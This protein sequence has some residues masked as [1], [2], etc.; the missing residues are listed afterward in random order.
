MS[1]SS[2]HSFHR[3]LRPLVAAGAFALACS[4]SVPALLPPPFDNAA[5]DQSAGQPILLLPT[6]IAVAP[7]GQLLVVSS[8]LDQTYDSGTLLSF[9][10][11]FI[12]AFFTGPADQV[13]RQ[14]VLP[15]TPD[16]WAAM[17]PAY[18]GPLALDLTGTTAWVGSRTTNR[19]T[20]V[21]LDTT[22]GQL[23][24]VTGGGQDCRKGT[25]DL[26]NAVNLD[27][28]VVALEGAYG[29]AA[30]LAS[31]AGE[32]RQHKVIFVAS[33]VPHI[34]EIISGVLQAFGRVAAVIAEDEVAD[35]AFPDA[36]L[37]HAGDVLYSVDISSPTLSSA[38][39]AGTVLFDKDRQ[40]IIL[41]G[42]YTR[43]TASSSGDP[44]TGKCSAVSGLNPIRFV[45]TGAG[46]G[47]QVRVFDLTSTV[48]G[49]ETTALVLGGE[50][51]QGVPQ[52]LYAVSRNPD[53][54]VEIAMPRF[55][56]QDPIVTR[57]VSLPVAPSNAIRLKR[58]AG[59]PGADL[60]AV[61]GSLN[62]TLSIY[63]AG[64]G[65]VVAQVNGLGDY[66]FQLT[67]LTDP[68]DRA[69]L[70]ATVFGSCSLAFVDVD[71]VQPWNARLRASIGK[72]RP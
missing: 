41:G 20:G 56:G 54:L 47:A 26:L 49:N 18:G 1:R 14:D 27:G 21:R 61:A 30:G 43:F 12:D 6:G 65:E 52:V 57:T 33:L 67:Q 22:T 23:S 9:S 51:A 50:D 69:R 32:T 45:E 11:A 38:I 70:V 29:V 42:C 3:A 13:V 64:A 16:V 19:A 25:V 63:D 2:R 62:G 46:S 17:V 59:H 53:V 31:R 58:P 15:R 7:T 68:G 39:G 55:P 36:Q 4:V 37:L 48:R 44:A 10:K 35:P 28:N 60:I 24:C 72:C 8:D 34:D 71:Y 66:P 40:Q 5:A